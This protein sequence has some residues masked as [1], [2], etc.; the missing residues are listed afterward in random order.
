MDLKYSSFSKIAQHFLSFTYTWRHSAKAMRM[1]SSSESWP[2]GNLQIPVAMSSVI[3]EWKICSS[4][5]P[6]GWSLPRSMQS[7]SKG[8]QLSCRSQCCW[9][10]VRSVEVCLP[11]ASYLPPMGLLR[12]LPVWCAFH[13]GRIRTRGRTMPS[14]CWFWSSVGFFMRGLM[15]S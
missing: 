5:R 9:A 3:G 15:R 11:I 7:E 10:W 8:R 13:C 4:V 6:H 2:T 12:T 14:K 1:S